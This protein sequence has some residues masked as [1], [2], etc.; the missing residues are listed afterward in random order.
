[1]SNLDDCIV[2]FLCIGIMRCLLCT[3]RPGRYVVLEGQSLGLS[4]KLIFF[5]HPRYNCLLPKTVMLLKI[6]TYNLFLEYLFLA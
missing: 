3:F 5:L 4:G 6:K 2:V 1:M